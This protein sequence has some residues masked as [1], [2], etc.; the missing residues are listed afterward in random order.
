MAG[1]HFAFIRSYVDHMDT[2]QIVLHVHQMGE[3]IGNWWLESSFPVLWSNKNLEGFVIPHALHM[4]LL[5][6]DQ[7]VATALINSLNLLF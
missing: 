5:L 7:R 1:P 2:R 6:H 4:L 3:K